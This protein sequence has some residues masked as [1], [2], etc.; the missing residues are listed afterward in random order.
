MNYKIC[1]RCRKKL[2]A[3]TENYHKKNDSKFN[4]HS[5]CK[6]CRKKESKINYQN[7]KERIAL[8]DKNYRKNNK[9]KVV[10]ESKIK[11]NKNKK[12]SL[13]F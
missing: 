6:E 10:T 12:A 7:N 4:L 13:L 5:A 2:E 3:T 1:S 8:R 9:E 11:Y